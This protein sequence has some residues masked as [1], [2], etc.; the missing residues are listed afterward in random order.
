MPSSNAQITPNLITYN[1]K[2]TSLHQ[3][4][5]LVLIVCCVLTLT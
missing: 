2:K 3:V 1:K 4:L 5:K